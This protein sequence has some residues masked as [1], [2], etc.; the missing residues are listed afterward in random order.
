LSTDAREPVSS[1]AHVTPPAWIEVR[2]LVPLGWHELVA[3]VLLHGSCAT[4]TT[5]VAFGRPS[6]A[7]DPPPEG[8]DFVRTFLVESDDSPAVREQLRRD[9]ADLARRAE[10]PE[11]E[12]LVVEFRALPPEDYATSW[13][14]TWKPFRVG[15]VCVVLPDEEYAFRA[16]D[17]PLRLE[18]GGAFGTGRHATTRDCLRALQARV[19]AGET[20]LDAGSGNGIL[21]VAATLL[22]AGTALGF[23][24][25]PIAR[26]YAE[27]L[28]VQNGVAER[29]TFRVGGFEVIGDDE[30]P[31]DAVVANIYSD[32][33]Q[34]HAE[35]LFALVKP[36][37]W[38]AFSGCP[39]QHRDATVAAIEA[40]GFCLEQ[41]RVRGRWHTFSGARP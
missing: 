38:F 39:A 31:F 40:A 13:R 5:G 36:G 3:E 7:T 12:G 22:G 21:S 37:G 4:L 1:P 19:R 27:I 11:L 10:A 41:E 34:E 8:F 9:L 23:D 26:S 30:G 16:T 17:L 18:P 29:C 20:V 28:A 33:I 25:D 24:I 15:R 6:L 35:R 14:K 2:V 32:V